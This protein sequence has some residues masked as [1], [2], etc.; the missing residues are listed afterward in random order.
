M[1]GGTKADVVKMRLSLF[2]HLV[3]LPGVSFMRYSFS[4]AFCEH[5]PIRRFSEHSQPPNSM[6]LTI[7]LSNHTFNP[8]YSKWLPRSKSSNYYDSS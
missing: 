8:Y 6:L 1:S 5:G 2:T 7:I 4:R 3:R